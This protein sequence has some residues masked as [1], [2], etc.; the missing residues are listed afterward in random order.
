MIAAVPVGTDITF[1]C[2]SGWVFDHDWY[3]APK[4]T[5]TCQENG[6]FDAPDEWP[7]CIN[8][9]YSIEYSLSL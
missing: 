7:L 5:I 4:F 8:R 3:Q 9:N 1:G 2:E 6:L